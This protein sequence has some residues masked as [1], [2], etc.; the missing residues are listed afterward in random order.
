MRKNKAGFGRP[1]LSS[2]P[3]VGRRRQLETRVR[4]VGLGTVNVGAPCGTVASE[5]SSCV[6]G[7]S[8]GF[9]SLSLL[10]LTGR[11]GV[12]VE[13]GGGSRGPCRPRDRGPNCVQ[14]PLL[15]APTP[16]L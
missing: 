1:V 7:W 15:Q 10:P 5:V 9:L 14:M 16:S 11:M 12:A 3:R 13:P 4:G 8:L 6:T 2:V